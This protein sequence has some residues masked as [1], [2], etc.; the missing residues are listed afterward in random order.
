MLREEH[1]QLTEEIETLY[2]E[3][4]RLTDEFGVLDDTIEG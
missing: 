4:E 3:W 1:T 2:R